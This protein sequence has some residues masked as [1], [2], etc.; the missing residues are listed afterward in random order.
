[1]HNQSLKNIININIMNKLNH[2]KQASLPNQEK[3]QTDPPDQQG[4]TAGR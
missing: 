2:I 3:N 1:M 4:A